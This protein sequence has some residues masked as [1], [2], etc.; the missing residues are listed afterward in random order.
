MEEETK[1]SAMDQLPPKF[2]FW[3]GVV[4]SAAVFALIGFIIMIMLAIKGVDLG[5]S[6]SNTNRAAAAANTNVVANTNAAAAV[7]PSGKIDVDSLTNVQ[8]EG[9][10][11]IVEYSDLECPF[12]QRFH[13]TLQQVVASNE[14]NVRWAYKHFPLTSI[15]TK[16]Q[17]AA[18]ASECAADQGKFWEYVDY[19]FN[20]QSALSGTAIED[21]AAAVGLNTTDFNDCVNS[22]KYTS[23]VNADAAEAQSL[24]GQGTPF[25]VIIDEDGNVLDVI[26]GALPLET[27]EAQVA[28]QL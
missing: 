9:D 4:T 25:S 20:N 24:G 3:A 21:G 12:C 8:G 7:A 22:G 11:T 18:E 23:A 2:A 28:K 13:P 17:A 19:I 15:H 26:S 10:I 27:V 16:A 14:G 1:K 6:T 5:D